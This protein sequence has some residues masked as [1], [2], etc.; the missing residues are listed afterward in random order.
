MAFLVD[1]GLPVVT[2]AGIGLGHELQAVATALDVGGDVQG[3]GIVA[4]LHGVVEVDSGTKIVVMT[5]V[6]LQLLAL[7]IGAVEVVAAILVI[8][9]CD[10][11]IGPRIQ[12]VLHDD[13]GLCQCLVSAVEYLLG[14]LQIDIDFRH[15][16][17]GGGSALI[18]EE[19]VLVVDS[20]SE[21]VF[22]LCKVAQARRHS[23]QSVR[24]RV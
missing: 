5:V 21:L 11:D 12:L 1:I 13:V 19:A 4:V 10:A 8:V 20:L 15:P 7:G 14:L 22:S 17:V 6:A 24:G 23:G 3:F 18:R 9:V 16:E 2:E